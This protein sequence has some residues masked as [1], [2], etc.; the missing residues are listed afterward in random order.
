MQESRLPKPMCYG[1]PIAFYRTGA[2]IVFISD[3]V[4]RRV[5]AGNRSIDGNI[6]MRG[7]GRIVQLNKVMKPLKIASSIIFLMKQGIF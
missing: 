5:A 2:N 7:L 3:H 4:I 6:T 1:T